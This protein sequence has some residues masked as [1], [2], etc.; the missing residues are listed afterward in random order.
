MVNTFILKREKRKRITNH[1]RSGEQ[2][3]RGSEGQVPMQHAMQ[4]KLR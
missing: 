2:S 1:V 3:V 4:M